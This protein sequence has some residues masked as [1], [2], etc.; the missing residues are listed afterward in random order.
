MESEILDKTLEL[1]EKKLETHTIKEI[2]SLSGLPEGWLKTL[3]KPK[4]IIPAVNRIEALYK[5]LT[6]KKKILI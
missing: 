1:F 6:G 5:F 4:K 3:R 2:S